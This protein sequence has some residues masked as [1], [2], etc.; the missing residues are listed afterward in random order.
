MKF[1]QTRM[2]RVASSGFGRVAAV[3]LAAAL[4][5]GGAAAQSVNSDVS[6]S[7]T[8]VRTLAIQSATNLGFGTLSPSATAGTVVIAAADGAR[9]STGGV[10][11]LPAS[12]G[13]ASK[14]DMVGSAGLAYTVSLPS[15][16]TLTASGGS[17]TMTLN[18]L[19]TSLASNAG[20]LNG[21]G[22]GSFNVGG[23]LNVAANQTVASYSGTFAVTVSW[24]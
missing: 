3:G 13:T 6:A 11:L 23:T 1:I 7:A 9:S 5:G 24:N 10:T 21:S 16:A 8:L 19:T 20:T 12:P 14:V 2:A 4:F 18:N 15:T 22:Q 17:A